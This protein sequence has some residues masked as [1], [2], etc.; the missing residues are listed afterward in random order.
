M[1]FDESGDLDAGLFVLRFIFVCV[2]F[3]EPKKK[4]KNENNKQT[5]PKKRRMSVRAEHLHVTRDCD[6]DVVARL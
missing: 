2:D 3:R 1:D 5:K 4:K 6:I